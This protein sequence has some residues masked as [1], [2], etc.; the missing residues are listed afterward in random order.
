MRAS[1]HSSFEAAVDRLK[2][3]S[4]TIAMLPGFRNPPNGRDLVDART[5]KATNISRYFVNFASMISQVE[6]AIR[7]HSKQN[8]L[9]FIGVTLRATPQLSST[10]GVL[11]SISRL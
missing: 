5:E 10:N 3:L 7:R 9:H 6:L 11:P 4:P 8:M 1:D 2:A